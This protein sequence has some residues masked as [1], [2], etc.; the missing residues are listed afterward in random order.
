MIRATPRDEKQH[1]TE[2]GNCFVDSS[3]GQIH[4]LTSKPKEGAQWKTP[5]ACFAPNPSTGRSFE[6][7]MEC[8][9]SDRRMLAPDYPGLGRS[10]APVGY[11]AIADYAKAMASVLTSMDFGID[12]A[13]PMDICGY[14]TGAYVAIEL[15]VMR[16]DLVRKVVLI[17]VPYYDVAGRER[18]RKEIAYRRTIEDDFE[19]IRNSWDFTVTNREP[20]V[21]VDRAYEQFI[22]VLIARKYRHVAY[23]AT[24]DYDADARAPFLKQPLRVLNPHA[25]LKKPTRDFMRL[26]PDAE[27]VE[28]PQ[29]H[30]GIFD[31]GV[32]ILTKEFRRF[33][34]E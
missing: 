21:T 5:L 6:L 20:G 19:S 7:F 15:A 17:G 9:G 29:L 4:V 14:H 23:N 32:E 16:P 25:D 22:D 2:F 27:L 34:D 13:G 11:M 28:L 31:V 33:L 18:E 1:T 3:Y 8:L 12:S 30:Y 10:D 24:F 26:V